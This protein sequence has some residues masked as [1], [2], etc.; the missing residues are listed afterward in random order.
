[1]C[2]L[3]QRCG[4]PWLSSERMRGFVMGPV[5]FPGHFAKAHCALQ[6]P[7]NTRCYARMLRSSLKKKGPRGMPRGPRFFGR[8]R[9]SIRNRL[10]ESLPRRKRRHGLGR[11][12]DLLAVHRIASRA[13]LALAR[14]EC[15]EPHHGYAVALRHT[16][17]DRIE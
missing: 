6:C 3:I 16:V 14:Q 13:C 12:P 15:A 7:R 2:Q 9:L 4:T 5:A 17:D 8:R 10:L 1:C 11:D